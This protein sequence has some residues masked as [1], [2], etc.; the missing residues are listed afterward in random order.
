MSKLKEA[1]SELISLAKLVEQSVDDKKITFAEGARLAVAGW[2][3]WGEIKDF[4]ALKDE[5]MSLTP[6]EKTELVAY[7]NEQFDLK[8]D[9]LEE[10]IEQIFDAVI[11]LSSVFG[12]LK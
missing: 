4:A 11:Q 2:R 5:F 10:L 1:L 3:F 9:N 7:F 6:D 8:H 12:K